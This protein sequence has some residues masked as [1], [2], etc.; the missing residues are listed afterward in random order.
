MTHLIIQICR[1]RRAG[2]AAHRALAAHLADRGHVRAVA[3]RLAA[4]ATSKPAHSQGL[5]RTTRRRWISLACGLV[6]RRPR[7]ELGT[8]DRAFVCAGLVE[9]A[10]VFDDGSRRFQPGSKTSKAG[11][12]GFPSAVSAVVDRRGCELTGAPRR[13][14]TYLQMRHIMG[15][16]DAGIRTPDPFIT[17][18][19]G[20]RAW[21]RRRGGDRSCMHRPL[22]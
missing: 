7:I 8:G 22:S 3:V 13:S 6:L 15:R 1:G 17:S 12:S 11:S 19:A 16:A 2:G 14:A 9:P 18:D 10:V 20:A 4:A 5:S 21:R